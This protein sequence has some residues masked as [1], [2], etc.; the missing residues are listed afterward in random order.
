VSAIL[1]FALPSDDADQRSRVLRCAAWLETT[2]E[3]GLK[4]IGH[5]QGAPASAPTMIVAVGVASM[6][7][8]QTI[9]SEWWRN[10]SPPGDAGVRVLWVEKSNPVGAV[11]P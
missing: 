9:A 10:A 3:G 6:E 1:L 2:G 11:F 5:E 8:A 4:F 7:H